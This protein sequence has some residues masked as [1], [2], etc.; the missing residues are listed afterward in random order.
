M[1]DLQ[2]RAA[3]AVP[4]IQ[5]AVTGYLQLCHAEQTRTAGHSDPQV[6]ERAATTWQRRRHPY[7]AIYAQLRQAEALLAQRHRSAQATE[8]LRS[9]YRTAHQLSAAPLLAQI[10]DL[11]TRARVPLP[12]DEAARPATPAAPPPGPLQ[13][14]QPG[15]RTRRSP[16]PQTCRS[17]P[18]ASAKCWPRSPRDG[19]TARSPS[20]CS[21]ARR[22]SACTSPTSS[23]RPAYVPAYRQVPSCIAPGPP[24][25]M[26]GPYLARAPLVT[27]SRASAE[28]AP[29]YA[30]GYVAAR[31]MPGAKPEPGLPVDRPVQDP[32]LTTYQARGGEVP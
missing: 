24:S 5:D 19:Q 7:P 20:G 3:Q 32:G 8:A 23:P 26:P 18:T 22:P 27:W 10:R 1:Q 2:Q 4:A 31:A 30:A 12:V 29:G 14:R 28:P 17:S 6:W 15:H 13:Y 16:R 9:A 21:S 11:A 25:G